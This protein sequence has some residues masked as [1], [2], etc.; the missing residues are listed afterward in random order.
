MRKLPVIMAIAVLSVVCAVKA[1][2]TSQADVV[3][4]KKGSGVRMSGPCFAEA[5]DKPWLSRSDWLACH[6][7]LLSRRDKLHDT[8]LVFL[9]DSITAG[10][11][12][13]GRA[14]WENY[15]AHYKPLNLGITGDETS[16]V[17]WRIENGELDGITPKAVVLLIG[18]NNIGNSGQ[19]G[20]EAA[21]GVRCVVQKIRARLPAA[22]I[23]LLAVFP[24]DERPTMK[25]RQEVNSLNASISALD[26]GQTVYC[27]DLASTFLKAD[28]SL[29]RDLF[30]DALHLSAKAYEMWAKAMMPTLR[31]LTE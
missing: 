18:T 31:K 27:V 7:N 29:P 19:T 1:D 9:G 30:P 4:G 11:L 25:F 17:L 16:Q 12:T 14:A 22:K 8:Q 3:A 20:Q 6:R 21:N 26:D 10:W 15:F 2:N 13:D 24:R 5:Q 23:L 28:G